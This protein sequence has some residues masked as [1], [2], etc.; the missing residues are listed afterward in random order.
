MEFALAVN[1]LYYVWSVCFYT[2]SK[3]AGL[4]KWGYTEMGRGFLQKY[5]ESLQSA[6]R[7]DA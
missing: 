7:S 1:Y 4:C 3:A 6:K 2:L 5:K